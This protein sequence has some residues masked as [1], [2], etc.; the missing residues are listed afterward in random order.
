M[1]NKI[2]IS[3]GHNIKNATLSMINNK[4][5]ILL[6]RAVLVD[7]IDDVVS[8]N[9]TIYHQDYFRFNFEDSSAGDANHTL[10][11]TNQVFRVS[12]KS[13]HVN[14]MQMK[15]TVDYKVDLISNSQGNYDSN[16]YSF[17]LSNNKIYTVGNKNG[18]FAIR[19]LDKF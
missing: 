12:S 18:K 17:L 14:P 9:D 13:Y 7:G 5:Y 3:D 8:N 10:F 15:S 11:W 4:G 6:N 19:Y 1:K 16:Q 2:F